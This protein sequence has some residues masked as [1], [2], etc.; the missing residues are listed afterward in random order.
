MT[1]HYAFASVGELHLPNLNGCSISTKEKWRAEVGCIGLCLLSSIGQRLTRFLC[2]YDEQ[3][4]CLRPTPAI[5]DGE[6]SLMRA[7]S[8]SFLEYDR[9][10]GSNVVLSIAKQ[11]QERQHKRKRPGEA[12]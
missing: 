11:R 4:V 1:G 5:E 9:V 10:L 12:S 2:L 6:I 3:R 7:T 8:P